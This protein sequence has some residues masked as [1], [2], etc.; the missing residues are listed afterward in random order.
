MTFFSLVIS[1]GSKSGLQDDV[2]QDVHRDRKVLV[3]YLQVE[4]RVLLGSEGIHVPADGV[5]LG[6]DHLGGAVPGA[7]EHHVLDEVAD[8]RDFRALVAAAALQPD[9]DRHAA[10]VRHRLGEQ[11]EAVGEDFPDDHVYFWALRRERDDDEESRNYHAGGRPSKCGR[12]AFQPCRRSY[13]L[14][15]P[16]RSARAVARELASAPGRSSCWPGAAVEA[17]PPARRRPRPRRRRPPSS[18]GGWRPRWPAA[19]W[20]PRRAPSSGSRVSRPLERPPPRCRRPRSASRRTCSRWRKGT[21]VSFP[22][23]DKVF[24]NVFS[25]HHRQRV[26][27]RPVP[28]RRLARACASRSPAS[29]AST[30]TSIRTWRATCGCWRA[31]S[32]PP[33]TTRAPSACRGSPPGRRV[34]QVW[35]ER[36]GEK[37]FPVELRARQEPD[38]ERRAGRL[39][40]SGACRT[41]TSSG[42]TTLPSTKDVDRY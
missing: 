30:A 19:R 39:R 15:W 31:A 42:R 28:Q 14:P 34:V 13:V 3:Q 38:A 10:D 41:R 25:R 18:S 35:N 8:A 11:G 9:P 5:D 33:P 29:C 26:R 16:F 22:N 37:Q 12:E 40:L 2:A 20:R 6:R 36:G 7:L 32:S 1:I 27:P 24:H 17:Q 4:R 21:V 23:L